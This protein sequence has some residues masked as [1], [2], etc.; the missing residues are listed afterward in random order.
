MLPSILRQLVSIILISILAVPLSCGSSPK[1][2]SRITSST[3]PAVSLDQSI[4]NA[5]IALA[6]LFKK[7]TELSLLSK[8]QTPLSFSQFSEL[9]PDEFYLSRKV[10]VGNSEYMATYHFKRSHSKNSSEIKYFIAIYLGESKKIALGRTRLTIDSQAE[11]ELTRL[12]I[13]RKL[14]L[15]AEEIRLNSFYHLQESG[16]FKNWLGMSESEKD[17]FL[18][19]VVLATPSVI[20]LGVSAATFIHY[21]Y[22]AKKRTVTGFVLR[23][24]GVAALLFVT[25]ASTF[26]LSFVACAMA[27]SSACK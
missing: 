8:D 10:A 25:F 26:Y 12:L 13:E 18:A 22:F 11:P 24:L 3:E 20:F 21:C 14:Q 1:N 2:S 9:D 6:D 16:S 23:T 19:Q 7:Q 15:L 27:G 5:Q 4:S 17:E